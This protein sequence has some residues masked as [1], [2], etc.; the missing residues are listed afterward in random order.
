MIDRATTKAMS[1]RMALPNSGKIDIISTVYL[2]RLSVPARDR[3]TRFCFTYLACAGHVIKVHR[4]IDKAVIRQE[5]VHHLGHDIGHLRE[6]DLAV[7]EG[8]ERGILGGIE[9]G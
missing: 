4:G 9:H 7:D 6:T 5:P 3:C 2:L 1:V 8:I